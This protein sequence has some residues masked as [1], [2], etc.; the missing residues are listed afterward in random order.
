LQG[1][2]VSKGMVDSRA[3]AWVWEA[4]REV[5]CREVACREVACREVAC[6]EAACR[7]AAKWVSITIMVACKVEAC[8]VVACKVEACRLVPVFLYIPDGST[9]MH[10]LASCSCT[11]PCS[12]WASDMVSVKCLPTLHAM[13]LVSICLHTSSMLRPGTHCTYDV[14]SLLVCSKACPIL[15]SAKHC[16][17]HCRVGSKEAWV[18]V[19]WVVLQAWA[20]AWVVVAWAALLEW[21]E[22]WAVVW[23]V[24]RVDAITTFRL[25]LSV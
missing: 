7:E 21:V 11:M 4:C 13:A 19:A 24:S 15:P 9:A 5:A 12:C 25:Q 23:V 14:H 8:K 1:L 16:A 6:R 17:I 20:V 2:V 10:V 18:V 3:V 22:A